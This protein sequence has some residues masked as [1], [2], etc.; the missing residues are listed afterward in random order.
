MNGYTMKEILQQCGTTE[1]TLRYYE[2]IGLLSQVRRKQNRHRIYSEHDKETVLLIKCLKKTGMS[3]DEIRPL[4]ALYRDGGMDGGVVEQ[5][6]SYQDKIKRQQMELQQV[7]DLIEHKLQSGEPFGMR[8][9]SDKGE[10]IS[11][12]NRYT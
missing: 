2:K 6:R 4:L 9:V 5:L 10:G 7:W 12:R 1:D 8:P 3:L 11:N